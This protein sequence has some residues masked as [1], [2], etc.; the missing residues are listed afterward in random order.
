M[1]YGKWNMIHITNMLVLFST[2]LSMWN[3]TYVIIVA[4]FF[5]GM[6]V[7][8]FSVFCPKFINEVAPDE[9]KGPFGALN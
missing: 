2:A 9:Y 5:Y 6:T 7:G 1:R 8:A 4:R 3:N